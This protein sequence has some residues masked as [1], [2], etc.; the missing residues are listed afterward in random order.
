MDL[1]TA[2]L[3]RF[4]TAHIYHYASYEVTGAEAP[5]DAIRNSRERPGPDAPRQALRRSLRHY[6]AGNSCVDGGLLAQGPRDHLL[7]PAIRKRHECGRKHRRYERWRAIGAQSILDDIEHY[8]KED[9]YSTAKLRDWLQG[10]RPVGAAVG[11]AVGAEDEGV[12]AA[13]EERAEQREAREAS[14]RELAERVRSAAGLSSS[15]SDLVAELLWFHQRAQK[16]QWWARF[17]R[18]TWTDEELTEDFES[19]G[20]LTMEAS[21]P[22][23]PEKRSLVATYRFEP[24]DT[25]LKIGQYCKF[26][27]TLK[28]AG[29]IQ[30]LDTEEGRVAL[31]RQATAGDFPP[32]G[33][34]VPSNIVPQDVLIEAVAAFAKRAAAGDT[35]GDRALI[36]LIERKLP[37]LNGHAAGAPIAAPGKAPS[38][39][40]VDA[41]CRLDDSYLVIQGPPGT[42]KT[43]T[44]ADAI[45]RLLGGGKRVA[46]SA[47]SHKVINHL[48]AAVEKR[49][50][51]AGVLFKG[52][53]RA[54]EASE[55][56]PYRSDSI[57]TVYTTVDI[58]ETF[59][60]VGGTAASLRSVEPAASRWWL[61][62]PVRR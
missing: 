50:A 3:E 16:P 48:L 14:R 55:D 53:K 54:S 26:A 10:L 43:H 39:A 62:L 25:K 2:H 29:S 59:Q 11:A 23:R 61:R 42:G 57:A 33:S 52:A 24:Q 30:D 1:F 4:P 47:N 21:T 9:C 7:G 22:I 5:R 40:A 28:S 32:S 58:D 31:K 17:D 13:A 41:V 56:S 20:G 45:V 19:L 37:R 36:D 49:A 15:S 51:E 12:D 60:L 8:N 38:E 44:T 18:Q 6:T 35:V 27:A 34:L 46:V